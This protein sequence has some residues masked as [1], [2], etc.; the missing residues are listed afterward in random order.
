MICFCF[1]FRLLGR[2]RLGEAAP[3]FMGVDHPLLV[4]GKRGPARSIPKLFASATTRLTSRPKPTGADKHSEPHLR[5]ERK[6]T[7]TTDVGDGVANFNSH[8]APGS[9]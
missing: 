9:S 4:M 7:M 6:E 3:W 5:E 8:L 2:F 1:G